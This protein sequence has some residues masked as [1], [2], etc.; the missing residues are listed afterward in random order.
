MFSGK[1]KPLSNSE[2]LNLFRK[3]E[4]KQYRFMQH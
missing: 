1:I 2:G 4:S 3:Q